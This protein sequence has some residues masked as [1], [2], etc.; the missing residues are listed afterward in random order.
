MA[1]QEEAWNKGSIDEFMNGYWE[2]K[3]LRFVSGKSG[4]RYGY[5]ETLNGYKKAYP[6]KSQMGILTFT[7]INVEKISKKSALVIGKWALDRE[8]EEDLEGHFSL[9]WKKIKGQWVIVVDHSS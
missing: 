3:E 8:K 9:I 1:L 6:D 4:I 2:S 5:E 7:L